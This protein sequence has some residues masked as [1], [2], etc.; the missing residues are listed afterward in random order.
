M[1]EEGAR[2]LPLCGDAGSPPA[3]AAPLHVRVPC[4]VVEDQLPRVCRCLAHIMQLRRDSQKVELGPV[5]EHHVLEALGKVAHA[6]DVVRGGGDE[7]QVDALVHERVEA[8]VDPRVG[9]GGAGRRVAAVHRARDVG[10]LRGDHLRRGRRR[11][12]LARA[13]RLLQLVRG[14]GDAIRTH[15]ECDGL[16]RVRLAMDPPVVLLGE[17]LLDATQHR[18][19]S[20]LEAEAHVLVLAASPQRHLV[21]GGDARV[22]STPSVLDVC[23]HEAARLG[24]LTQPRHH[25]RHLGALCPLSGA[26]D[27]RLLVQLAHRRAECGVAVA[28]ARRLEHHLPRLVEAARHRLLGHALHRHAAL[29]ARG[30]ATLDERHL[31]GTPPPPLGTATGPRAGGCGVALLGPAARAGRHTRGA[32]A[33]GRPGPAKGPFRRAFV[34]GATVN[35]RAAAR[36]SPSASTGSGASGVGHGGGAL[37]A[38]GVASTEHSGAGLGQLEAEGDV[39]LE[40]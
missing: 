13:G 28:A 16:E 34:R 23:R 21:V 39:L 31:L 9:R 3:A 29:G 24:I 4:R 40:Q 22:A 8:H 25:H 26:H 7:E 12:R 5:G 32:D 19:A 30:R 18:L 15:I 1:R 38:G 33:G 14:L 11:V 20:L 36:P 35:G 37:G 17:S 27:E 2:P 10:E 6:L